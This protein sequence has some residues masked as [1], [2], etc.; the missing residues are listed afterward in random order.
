VS[1]QFLAE[2]G[3]ELSRDTTRVTHLGDGFDCLGTA[4]R[5]YHGKLLCTPA[6]KT[7]RAFLA[8]VRD[9]VRR[10][11]QATTG[12]VIMQ[13][14]PVMR[15]W[16]QSHQHG[17]STPTFAK[18]DH[19]ISTMLW[20]GARRRHPHTSRWWM[21]DKDLRSEHGNHGVCFGHVTR[22]DGARADVRLCRASSV[23]MRRHTKM[24]GEANPY[25]PQWESSFE[26][27]LER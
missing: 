15:G 20:Q 14:N 1:A 10:Q 17:S 7:V 19:H 12:H 18:V 6:K 3:L 8:T 24:K 4:V 25:A 2:R 13:R 11:K 27:R 26:A 21:R 5:K 22:T 16:A 9:M 23:P